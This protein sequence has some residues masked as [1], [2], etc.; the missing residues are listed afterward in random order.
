MIDADQRTLKRG[1]NRAPL[2]DLVSTS[3]SNN[4]WVMATLNQLCGSNLKLLDN[5]RFRIK[6]P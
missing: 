2:N 1:E 6:I 3:A 5:I 4:L